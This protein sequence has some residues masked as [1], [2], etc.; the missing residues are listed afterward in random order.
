MRYFNEKIDY[1]ANFD[2][3]N[4]CAAL[5]RQ[6]QEDFERLTEEQFLEKV[7][8]KKESTPFVFKLAV[9][10]FVLLFLVAV[11]SYS[12][13][14]VSYNSFAR[15]NSSNVKILCKT[16]EKFD[17]ILTMILLTTLPKMNLNYNESQLIHERIAI[18]SKIT[19]EIYN[20]D[21]DALIIP[22][23]ETLKKLENDVNLKINEYLL[24]PN[25]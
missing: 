24:N 2:E 6:Q 9:I 4:D 18:N 20:I 10:T 25:N 11:G 3:D 17:S 8:R 15:K 23:G 14:L 1:K 5:P 19:E 16:Y 7:S 12:F 21:L 13:M 22:E